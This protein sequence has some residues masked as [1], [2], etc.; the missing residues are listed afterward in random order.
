[1]NTQGRPLPS[2]DPVRC[3]GCGRCVELCPTAAVAV[4]DGCAV[5]IEPQACTFCE[6]CETFCPTGAIGRPFIVIFAPDDRNKAINT[7]SSTTKE[8]STS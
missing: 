1:M 7:D 5:I 6:V 4:I 3:N 2:I 8:G